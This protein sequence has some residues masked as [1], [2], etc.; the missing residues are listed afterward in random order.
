M[1][2]IF[3]MGNFDLRRN[4]IISSMYVKLNFEESTYVASIFLPGVIYENVDI[5]LIRIYSK[6]LSY[7][8]SILKVIFV[9]SN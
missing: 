4:V 5:V 9:K 2:A 3:I 1:V 8:L 6:H 7:P